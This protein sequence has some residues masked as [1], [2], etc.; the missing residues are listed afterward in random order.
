MLAHR[1]ALPYHRIYTGKSR[2]YHAN[3]L[4]KGSIEVYD[5]STDAASRYFST[6]L[7]WSIKQG[8]SVRCLRARRSRREQR[9]QYRNQYAAASAANVTLIFAVSDDDARRHL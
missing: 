9:P 3:T 4:R 7:D 6:F 1:F 2:R 8:T 5:T